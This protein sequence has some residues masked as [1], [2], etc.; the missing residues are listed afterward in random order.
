M[1][2]IYIITLIAICYS[3]VAQDFI[4]QKEIT[5]SVIDH[6]EVNELDKIYDLFNDNMKAAI[7]RE[8]LGDL[9]PSLAAQCGAYYGSGSTIASEVQGMVVVNQFLDFEKTDVDIRLAFDEDNKIA[10]LF[11]V[12]PVK[13]KE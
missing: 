13:K 6:F 10:G 4:V 3:A 1:K 9:W 5:Q 8:K 11:F 12:P 2:I 7:T